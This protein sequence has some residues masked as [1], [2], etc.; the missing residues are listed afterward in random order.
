[1]RLRRSLDERPNGAAAGEPR[2]GRHW[3]ERL[4]LHA[5][6]GSARPP[7]RLRR[8]GPA[9]ALRGWGRD[10]AD[11]PDGDRRRRPPC[12]VRRI[13]PVAEYWEAAFR[14]SRTAVRAR[15][16]LAIRRRRTRATTDA[17]VFRHRRW[18]R[19]LR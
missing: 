17:G 4:R 14:S 3:T 15:D 18:D 9:L 6:R 13:R 19:A 10:V 2:Q 11:Y 5:R 8:H 16:V 1:R 7:S 12:A